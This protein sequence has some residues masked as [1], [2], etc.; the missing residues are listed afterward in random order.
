MPFSLQNLD[1]I[2]AQA[3]HPEQLRDILILMFREVMMRCD[4]NRVERTGFEA[5]TEEELHLAF[6]R[7]VNEMI[8]Q[9]GRLQDQ[10]GNVVVSTRR[11]GHQRT[12]HISG[13]LTGAPLRGEILLFQSAA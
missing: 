5:A 6:F 4:G 10:L 13:P 7:T 2:V 12:Q 9:W 11:Y 3:T 1:T 8:V